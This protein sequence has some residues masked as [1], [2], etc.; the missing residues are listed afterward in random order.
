ML[1]DLQME[2]YELPNDSN[3]SSYKQLNDISEKQVLFQQVLTM[4]EYPPRL[5]ICKA[6][7]VLKSLPLQTMKLWR[8]YKY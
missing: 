2:K 1:P 3:P 8:Q 6:S 5:H 7:I 4:L